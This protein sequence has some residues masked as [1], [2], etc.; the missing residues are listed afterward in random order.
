MNKV[1]LM[2]GMMV[3]LCIGLTA[4]VYAQSFPEEIPLPELSGEYAVGV[5]YYHLIDANRPE[6]LTD[7]EDDQ[8]ELMISVFYPAQ[9]DEN[10]VNAPYVTPE[11]AQ[12]IESAYSGLGV[13]AAL[14]NAFQTHAYMNVSVADGLFP[15]VLFSHG[16]GV[17]PQFYRAMLEELASH[18]YIV[19]SI[20]H[21]YNA[22]VVTFPD[23]RVVMGNSAGNI[24][25]NSLEE[26]TASANRL[27]EIWVAD[28]SFVLDELTRLNTDDVL[29]SGHLDLEH[30]G[31]F[32]HSFGGATAA[33]MTVSD[34]R[35]DAG[36]NMD[37][38]LFGRVANEGTTRP[39]MFM[40]SEL[41]RA[42][43]EW[44]NA[45][46]N[47]QAG[48]VVLLENSDHNTYITDQLVIAQYIPDLVPTG[49][50]TVDPVSA[51]NVIHTYIV[52]F[53]DYNLKDKT[54]DIFTVPAPFE[55]VDVTLFGVS[56]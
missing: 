41:N 18:G 52:A 54:T 26:Q 19:V 40:L 21:T 28:A 38:T 12:N 39:F 22:T 20:A 9:V 36:I 15:V 10:A 49:I 53:F 35:F 44:E 29:L 45:L 46:V 2:I 30:V 37:G 3:F 51:L 56:E 1:R 25:G 4:N 6:T 34:E 27:L 32:G 5:A 13:P 11:E 50:G 31:M 47:S 14:L 42:S 48:Y 17:I 33:E 8:R 55:G 23:G 43:Q 24:E 7:D 16:A